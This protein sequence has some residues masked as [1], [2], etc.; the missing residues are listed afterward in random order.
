MVNTG[1]NAFNDLQRRCAAARNLLRPWDTQAIPRTAAS[2]G[3]RARP[4]ADARHNVVH[5]AP[6]P[7]FPGCGGLRPPGGRRAAVRAAALHPTVR[8]ASRGAHARTVGALDSP[9]E[10]G[11]EGKIGT[12]APAALR[13][14]WTLDRRENG[15]VLA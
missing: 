10:L 2:N 12:L 4:G 9:A 6:K 11:G 15:S 14:W 8:E 3:S 1:K 7:H 13:A 5:A